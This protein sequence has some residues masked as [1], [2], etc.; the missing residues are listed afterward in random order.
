MGSGLLI[1]IELKSNLQ[2]K[3]KLATYLPLFLCLIGMHL[4][5]H[6]LLFKVILFCLL[7]L[8]LY[9]VALLLHL[10]QLLILASFLIL[11]SFTLLLCLVSFQLFNLHLGQ[12]PHLFRLTLDPLIAALEDEV[13]EEMDKAAN[14]V[15]KDS[16][17]GKDNAGDDSEMEMEVGSVSREMQG[18]WLNMTLAEWIAWRQGDT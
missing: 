18:Q 10:L 14:E 3:R 4:C 13:A 8:L 11:E 17:Q 16:S 1:C 2:K 7:P 15:D 12:V 9:P 6:L 5:C